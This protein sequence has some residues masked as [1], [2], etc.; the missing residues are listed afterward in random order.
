MLCFLLVGAV[1]GDLILHYQLSVDTTGT[2]ELNPYYLSLTG[3]DDVPVS[4]VPFG[5]VMQGDQQWTAE[6]KL[7]LVNDG[8]EVSVAFNLVGSLAM[9]VTVICYDNTTGTPVEWMEGN[10]Y[11]KLMGDVH[12]SVFILAF[13]VMADYT[14][15][16]GSIGDFVLVFDSM[17]YYNPTSYATGAL[18]DVDGTLSFYTDGTQTTEMTEVVWEVVADSTGDWI[19]IWIYGSQTNGKWTTS[20]LPSGVTMEAEMYGTVWNEWPKDSPANVASSH[21]YRF[22]L[23]FDPSVVVEDFMFT[24]NFVN[25]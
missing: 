23:V 21:Q 13:L 22:R 12:P 10:D 9:G 20:T 11:V 25:Y 8:L 18:V 19:E 6:Y 5:A 16:A 15:G 24:L 4:T 1:V 7:V 17:E 14:A 2:V 3:M